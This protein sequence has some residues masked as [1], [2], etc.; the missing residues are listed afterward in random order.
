M[1][2]KRLYDGFKALRLSPVATET[3]RCARR[4]L[5]YL[6]VALVIFVSIVLVGIVRFRQGW[7]V[8]LLPVAWVGGVTCAY[9]ASLIANAYYDGKK[10]IERIGFKVCPGCQYD[11]SLL[12]ENGVCPECGKAY[13]PA[14]LK[15]RWREIYTKLDD[16]FGR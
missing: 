1:L 6:A 5:F 2:R 4:R 16:R 7:M 14:L 3:E 10:H 11:L 8:F 13:E 12:P 15:A 9:L